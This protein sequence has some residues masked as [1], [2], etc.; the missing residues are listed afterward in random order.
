MR[1]AALQAQYTQRHVESA[2]RNS[3]L[4]SIEGGSSA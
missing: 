4:R 3:L 1:S 2:E